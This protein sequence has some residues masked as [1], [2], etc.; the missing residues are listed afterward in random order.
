MAVSPVVRRYEDYLVI[1]EGLSP[2]TVECYVR[3]I[4][5]LTEELASQGE[6]PLTVQAPVLI[7]ILAKRQGDSLDQRTVARVL[8]SYRSFFEFLLKSGERSEN[9][10]KR[11][12]MPKA[13]MGIPA[14]FSVDE[15]DSFLAAI[16]IT[17]PY[18]FRDRAL[19][20]LIYSCGLRIQE[21]SSLKIQ[22]L[23]LSEGLIRVHGKGDKVRLVPLGESAA[24]WLARYLDGIRPR[25]LGARLLG[26]KKQGTQPAVP[27]VFLNNR[28]RRLS[29]KGMWKRFAAIRALAGL[30]GKVHTFRHSFA[31]HLLSGGADLRSVQELLGHADIGTTQIYT[32]LEQDEMRKAH[33]LYHPRGRALSAEA[34]KKRESLKAGRENDE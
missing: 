5:R 1:E 13:R 28:G 7:D 2:L 20:E 33:R 19:F 22:D 24:D 30:D 9:P 8:T 23:F 32:H 11:I 31:T 10:A 25:L 12:D 3:E 27:E 15:V 18:G 6:D 17:D 29:R 16:D 4:A 14:V 26:A 21:A 34:G